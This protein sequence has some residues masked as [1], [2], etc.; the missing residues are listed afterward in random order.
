M[1]QT[2]RRNTNKFEA[3]KSRN[4]LNKVSASLYLLLPMILADVK[5]TETTS[6]VDLQDTCKVPALDE[7]V[8]STFQCYHKLCCV[9]SML[10]QH[11]VLQNRGT[12]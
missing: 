1:S 2:R 6:S 10:A 11:S 8:T 12:S 7:G 5:L 4:D 3:E 9:N